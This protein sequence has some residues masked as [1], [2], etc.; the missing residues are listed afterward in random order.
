VK[1]EYV[2]NKEVKT[3]ASYSLYEIMPNINCSLI[4]I[5]DK[6]NKKTLQKNFSIFI[7]YLKK[8]D[9]SSPI[10]ENIKVLIVSKSNK[11]SNLFTSTEDNVREYFETALYNYL[12][13]NDDDNRI[14]Y[15]NKRKFNLF[16]RNDFED[17]HYIDN[18]IVD[19]ILEKY[20]NKIIPV[21]RFTVPDFEEPQN[22]TTEMYTKPIPS[23][24][25]RRRLS[26][27]KKSKKSKK[28]IR[29]N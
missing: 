29:K 23:G 13:Y 7:D 27:H 6:I 26:T 4:S 11:K 5:L 15:I 22:N 8:N 10:F 21:K 1:E 3:Y 19:N 17:L 16:N 9:K 25:S 12:N 28:H 14:L 20:Y 2:G 24:G 18:V